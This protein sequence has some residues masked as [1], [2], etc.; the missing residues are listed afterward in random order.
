MPEN[1]DKTVKAVRALRPHPLSKLHGAQK[2][3]NGTIEKFRLLEVQQMPAHREH[4]QTRCGQHLFQEHAA[5]EAVAV[6]VA[7]DHQRSVPSCRAAALRYRRNSAASAARR[8][9]Y[10]LSPSQNGRSNDLETP[11]TRGVLDLHRYAI[12]FVRLRSRDRFHALAQQLVRAGGEIMHEFFP[13][14]AFDAAM[15]ARSDDEGQ[16]AFRVTQAQ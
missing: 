5:L 14:R 2:I 4:V 15:S 6:L 7:D 16:A 12:G 3:L 10:R 13:V 8:A 9:R 1:C 11:P